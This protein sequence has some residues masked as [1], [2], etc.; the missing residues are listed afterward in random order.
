MTRT[1][2]R[3]LRRCRTLTVLALCAWLALSS[4]AWAMPR[5]DECCPSSSAMSAMTM[6]HAASDHDAS[7]APAVSTDSCC[8]HAP[9]SVPDAMVP[10]V[11]HVQAQNSSW[12]A[13]R[14]QAP[15]PINEPPLRPPV[16]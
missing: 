5:H 16:A 9:A 14:E 13:R 7:H 15:Q 1:L 3:H 12:M 6:P 10:H 8:A 11:L 2:L 4:V